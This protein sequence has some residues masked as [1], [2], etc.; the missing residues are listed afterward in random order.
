LILAEFL[1]G[2]LASVGLAAAVLTSEQTSGWTLLG[3]WLVGVGL[4]YLP[5][6][7]HAV[8]LVR[9]GALERELLGV[10]VRAEISYYSRSQF[11]LVVPLWVLLSATTSLLGSRDRGT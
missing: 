1:L 10:D 4:N 9:N 8:N 7:V 5:L 3:F 6:G 2:F 11:R